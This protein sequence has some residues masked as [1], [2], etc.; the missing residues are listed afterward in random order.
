MI[1]RTKKLYRVKNQKTKEERY[2]RKI[3]VLIADDLITETKMN[4][5]T[6]YKHLKDSNFYANRFYE[7]EVTRIY[8]DVK[9]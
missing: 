7:I 8:E 1:E 6:L 5:M 2:Y 9:D 3:V 4:R